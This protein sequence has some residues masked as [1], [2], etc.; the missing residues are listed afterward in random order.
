MKTVRVPIRR[1][2][3]PGY[4]APDD[5]FRPGASNHVYAAVR[6]CLEDAGLDRH[7]VG[8]RGWNPFGQMV[9]PGGRV[10]VLCNFV[11]HRLAGREGSREFAAKCTHASLLRPVI[12]YALSAVGPEGV[13]EVGNAPIQG[14]HWDAMQRD[15]GLD[16]LIAHYNH[17]NAPVRAVDL[18]KKHLLS[19]TQGEVRRTDIRSVSIDLGRMSLLEE[20]DGNR[21]YRVLQYDPMRT[22]A[23][24]GPGKHVY[25]IAENV[26]AADLI[27]SVPKL[28]THQ[29]VGMTCA[30][31]GTVGAVS[32]KDCLA[33]HRRGNPNEGGDEY[34]GE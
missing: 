24:H 32:E 18:R 29:K 10:F 26:L 9:E 3:C 4:P 23:F 1:V 15:T 2:P 14:A 20:A 30:L 22:A 33:H 21:E 28:K 16:Q 17:L 27:I 31:K 8:T 19:R 13:V 6:A 7:R 34:P 12:D 11:Y 25:Q 5:G